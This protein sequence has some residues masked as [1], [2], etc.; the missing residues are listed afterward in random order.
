MALPAP[1]RRLGPTRRVPESALRIAVPDG[2][3]AARIQLGAGKG[4]EFNVG[5]EATARAPDLRESWLGRRYANCPGP[6]ICCPGAKRGPR[7]GPRSIIH[8]VLQVAGLEL[9]ARTGCRPVGGHLLLLQ[10][11]FLVAAVN[12]TPE[13]GMAPV[14]AG[15]S[16]TLSSVDIR[17]ARALNAA[18][19]GGSRERDTGRRPGSGLDL[20]RP[21]LEAVL[22][23]PEPGKRG[24]GGQPVTHSAEPPGQL[25]APPVRRAVSTAA[26]RIGSRL[27]AKRSPDRGNGGPAVSWTSQPGRPATRDVHHPNGSRPQRAAAAAQPA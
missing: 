4:L 26:V 19:G 22:E 7:P 23:V 2:R 25:Q 17:V 15:L 1:D 20:L 11:S 9:S 12:E 21:D 18:R 5:A 8:S 16:V 27:M 13:A 10:P 24:L 6:A 14:R 3:K